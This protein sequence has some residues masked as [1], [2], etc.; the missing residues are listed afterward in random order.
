MLQSVHGR[1]RHDLATEQQQYQVSRELNTLPS[2][3][4]SF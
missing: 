3:L 4:V 1:I 2:V